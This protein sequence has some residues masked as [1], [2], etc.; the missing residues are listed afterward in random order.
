MT[1]LGTFLERD[2]R[3]AVRFVRDYPHPI[4]RLWDA[5]TRPAE[6]VRWFPSGVDLELRVG[7]TV[8][9]TGDPHL[10][11]TQGTVLA[12]DRPSRLS[13]SWSTDELHF[14]LQPLDEHSC[15]F[16]LINVLTERDAAARNATGWTICLGELNRHLA[17]ITSDGPHGASAPPFQPIY[18]NYVA[19][20]LPF[21]PAIPD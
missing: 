17:G 18:D 11:S 6:L 14:E 8:T 13:L 2:G 3:P 9:F 15:R 5:I 12:C 19:A 16:T 7:G 1:D 21:G 20:G 10:Q 4:E